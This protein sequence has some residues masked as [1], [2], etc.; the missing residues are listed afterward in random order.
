MSVVMM[1]DRFQQSDRNGTSG[2]PRIRC[3][4]LDRSAS[5]DLAALSY[6][7]DSIYFEKTC[8]PGNGY[9]ISFFDSIHFQLNN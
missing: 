2:T 7:P 4:I 8:L 9:R 5:M 6:T 1:A 3:F